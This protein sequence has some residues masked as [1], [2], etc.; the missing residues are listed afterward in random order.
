M[1]IHIDSI[2]SLLKFL[3]KNWSILSDKQYCQILEKTL[4][5]YEFDKPK[6]KDLAI[7]IIHNHYI[8][9]LCKNAKHERPL[10]LQ[11]EEI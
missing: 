5:V 2:D 11:Y 4:G 1:R 8:K 6:N 10:F 3:E 7:K 9:Y